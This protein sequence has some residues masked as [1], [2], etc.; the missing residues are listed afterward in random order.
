MKRKIMSG[1]LA[2]VMMFLLAFPGAVAYEIETETGIGEEAGIG[3]ETG[4]S[5][6]SIAL[7]RIDFVGWAI[8]SIRIPDKSQVLSEGVVKDGKITY[9]VTVQ[10]QVKKNG[11]NYSNKAV[12]WSTTASLNNT[13]IVSKDTRT[14]ASGIATATFH[15][16]GIDKLPVTISCDGMNSSKTI[17][18]GTK[19][20]YLSNFTLTEYITCYEGDSIYTGQKVSK[21]G[22]SG[23]YKQDFLADVVRNG[24]GKGEDG[25]WIQCYKGVYSHTAPTT[26]TMT[27]PK[28]GQTIASDPYYIPCVYR[29][30]YLRGYVD[31]LDGVGKRIAE[32]TGDAIKGHRIDLYTGIGRASLTRKDGSYRVLFCGVNNWGKDAVRPTSVDDMPMEI[33][34]VDVSPDTLKPTM[35][36]SDDGKYTAYVSNVD[37]TKSDSITIAIS[38]KNREEAT[39]LDEEIALDSMAL[40]VSSME[41]NG[42]T[43]VTIGNVN[44]SLQVYEEFSL[45]S[46][47]LLRKL[48][49]YA[50]T[51]V[52]SKIFYVQAPQ[53][54]SGKS[55][56]DRI[57]D[58]EGNIYYE[59]P[60]NVSIRNELL[61]QG[62]RLIFTERDNNTG[63]TWE[64]HVSLEALAQ[65]RSGET[66]NTYYK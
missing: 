37:L 46:N 61:L 54:F 27:T 23:T 5:V 58:D 66:E 10:V 7:D 47:E 29:S 2:A 13:R 16:Y 45:L 9:E 18:F 32:D 59:S 11:A 36:Q 65:S 55:G 21:P 56:T 26:A 60:E 20:T 43:L 4:T 15:V 22:L 57:L 34:T 40:S 31:I 30:G 63:E 39:I 51:Q 62:E 17:D 35:C 3:E 1:F 25:K 52:G 41:I 19:A 24:S 33:D 6:E 28:A 64:K 38:R 42:D 53:H 50:F 14:N 44:P 8:P 48:Y 12:T 49:G